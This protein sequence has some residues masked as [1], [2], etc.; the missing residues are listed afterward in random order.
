MMVQRQVR[1]AVLF[2]EVGPDDDQEKG[3]LYV[4]YLI[5]FYCQ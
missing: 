3:F 2:R 1:W 5:L 4:D